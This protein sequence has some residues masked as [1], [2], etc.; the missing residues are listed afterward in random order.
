MKNKRGISN[1]TARISL[2]R[3]QLIRRKTK[4]RRT[5]THQNKMVHLKKDIPQHNRRRL[6][7]KRKKLE[8]V[9]KL[10][11][12]MTLL[13]VVKVIAA[14]IMSLTHQKRKDKEVRNHLKIREWKRL[15][16]HLK[17]RRRKVKRKRKIKSSK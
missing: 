13:Q 6:N 8:V 5:L 3:R 2:R 11:E 16:P 17:V 10:R 7:L 4:R 1:N 12:E 15:R 9:N 14:E